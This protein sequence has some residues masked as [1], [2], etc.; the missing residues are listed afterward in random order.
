MFQKLL[1]FIKY[2]NAFSIAVAMV[3]VG[4]A[5]FAASPDLQQAVVASH[6]SINSVDNRALLA[7]DINNLDPQLQI[8]AITED[9]DTYYIQYHYQTYDIEDFIWQPV[10]KEDTLKVAKAALRG[11]DL[12]VYVAEQLGQVIDYQH[13]YLAEVQKRERQNGETKKVATV[14]YSGLI[15][16]F[17]NPEEKTFPGYEP[18]VKAPEPTPPVTTAPTAATSTTLPS[19]P[20]TLPIMPSAPLPTPTPTSTPELTPTPII[21][22]TPTQTSTSTLSTSSGQ[23]EPILTSTTTPE[24]APVS[25]PVVAT[26]TETVIISETATTTP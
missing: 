2:H 11:Q 14:T 23:A 17:L 4:S 25:E 18:V 21:I 12:G 24:V 9:S 5:A 19:V 6:E 22:S 20:E 16:K 15:G 1:N 7:L 3:I 10:V 8:T 26:S 13:S